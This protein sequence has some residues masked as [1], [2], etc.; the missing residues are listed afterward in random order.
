MK[1]L[2][3]LL[4]LLL[5]FEISISSGEKKISF[6]GGVIKSSIDCYYDYTERY[7]NFQIHI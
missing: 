7:Y 2:F 5:F 4:V 3:E 6:L 1:H